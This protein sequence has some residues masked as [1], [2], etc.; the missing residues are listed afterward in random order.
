MRF[1]EGIRDFLEA[2]GHGRIALM[3][4]RVKFFCQLS[5]RRFDLGIISTSRHAENGIGIAHGQKLSSPRT[6]A[7]PGPSHG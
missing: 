5:E 4:V 1:M 3:G 6:A 7:R 2:R